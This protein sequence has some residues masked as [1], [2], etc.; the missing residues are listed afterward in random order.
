MKKKNTDKRRHVVAWINKAEWDQV[1]EY[2]YSKDCVLQKYALHRISAWKGRYAHTTPIA[3]EN[4]ADLVRC[5]IL[6]NS[7]KLEADDLVLLYGTALVRFVNSMTERLQKKVAQPL[8]RLASQLKIPE[9]IVNLRH[10]ITH[11]K[12]PTL[13]W[14]RKG[15][16]FVLEWLQQ[17]YWSRQLVGGLNNDWDSAS[18]GEEGEELQKQE[19][20]LID[21]QK[22]VETYKTT[23]ELLIS[24]EKE[25]FQTFEELTGGDQQKRVWPAPS[26]D[27]SWILAQIK[28]FALE[29][30]ETLIDV[31]L[32]D[33]FLVPTVE[34]LE[35][36]GVDVSDNAD[37]TAPCLPRVFLRFWLPLLRLLTSPLLVHLLLEKMF[38]ELKQQSGESNTHSCYYLAAWISELLL[39]NITRS[40]YHYETK[41]EKK[42]R[43]R[44]RIFTNRI[45]LKCQQFL[46][47]CLDTPCLASPHLLKQ[48]LDD[49][50]HP[51]PVDTQQKLL[52]L[53][54]IYTQGPPS[55]SHPSQELSGQTIYT[56]ESL[57]ERLSRSKRPATGQRPKA[58][59]GPTG[60][61][62]G[63]TEAG[64]EQLSA[65]VLAER[66]RELQGSPWQVCTDKVQWSSFPLGKVPGQSEDPSFLMVENYSTITVFDQQGAIESASHHNVHMGVPPPLRANDG[67]LW[68]HSDVSKLKAGLQLF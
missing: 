26:A 21:R 62:P 27:M 1:L 40:E 47:A 4:T 52:R 51:F 50:D 65:D 9:W 31:L 18:D 11:R 14:C 23:R 44:D 3:V 64:Q 43:I 10:E 61:L 41:I 66:A 48:I 35:S 7:G 58:G 30:S 54:S 22:E 53:C 32:E 68:T 60:G 12:L 13:K 39:C 34:Q 46:S 17:E 45:H 29:S 55:E 20:E 38:Q 56:L 37:P 5:Q 8:R 28:H 15:C 19:N 25:Q 36:L 6:D 24:Y 16:Q 63:R 49:M 33:G 42:A 57:H 67:S 2:L 59:C